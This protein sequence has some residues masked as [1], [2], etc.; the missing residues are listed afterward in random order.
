MDQRTNMALHA[1]YAEDAVDLAEEDLLDHTLSPSDFSVLRLPM[2]GE[3]M[4]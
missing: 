4:S 3:D 2:P 1:S